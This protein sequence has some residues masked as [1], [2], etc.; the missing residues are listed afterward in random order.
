MLQLIG[1][2]IFLVVCFFI[3]SLAIAIIK[4]AIIFIA[5]LIGFILVAIC[6]LIGGIPALIGF[7]TEK[8]CS[9]L[10]IRKLISL[11]STICL[12]LFVL[13]TNSSHDLGFIKYTITELLLITL[14]L[15]HKK[16]KISQ[17]F[18]S[19]II[20]FEKN[21]KNFYQWYFTSFFLATTAIAIEN[22]EINSNLSLAIWIYYIFSICVQLWIYSEEK[23]RTR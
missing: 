14:I 3:L 23:L 17:K 7:A 22:Q 1:F 15:T 11:L 9:L 18:S 13:L 4:A 6:T 5:K 19:K 2:V 10:R 20:F 8:I 16:Q 12:P 21:E